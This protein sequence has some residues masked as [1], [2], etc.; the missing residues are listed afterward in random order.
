[1][2]QRCGQLEGITSGYP[3]WRHSLGLCLGVGCIIFFC[4]RQVCQR[5]KE[6]GI[7]VVSIYLYS[8][9]SYKVQPKV[10]I[11]SRSLLSDARVK[12]TCCSDYIPIDLWSVL[13]N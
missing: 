11:S 13:D 2:G 6:R 8:E 7:C 9:F 4:L 12:E 10:Y 1:M 3:W 5:N